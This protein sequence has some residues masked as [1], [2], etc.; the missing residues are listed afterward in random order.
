[1]F[2]LPTLSKPSS[3]GFN[4]QLVLCGSPEVGMKG[5]SVGEKLFIQGGI[6]Q[7]LRTDGRRRL[8]YRPISVETD[9]ISQV[10]S[11]QSSIFMA[12]LLVLFL[13][14]MWF[15]F[16]IHLCLGEW[17]SKGQNGWY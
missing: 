2:Q 11:K 13:L 16:S 14:F 15:Y 17:F 8:T 7:D 9:V 4:F 1:M 6:A 10:Y 5:L 12:S 3:S